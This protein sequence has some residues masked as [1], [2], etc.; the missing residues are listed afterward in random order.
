VDLGGPVA[1][2][3]VLDRL[4]VARE[5]PRHA[6][7]IRRSIASRG[8]YYAAVAHPCRACIDP[9][10]DAATRDASLPNRRI[11]RDFGLSETSVRRHRRHLDRQPARVKPGPTLEP[12]GAPGRAKR[13]NLRHRPQ[14]VTRARER[15][16]EEQKARYLKTVGQVGTLTAGCRAAR[17]SPH[18]VYAWRE[19]DLAFAMA[20]NEAR[21]AFADGIEE[22]AIRRAWHGI[23]RPIYQGGKLVGYETVYSDNLLLQLLKALKPEKYRERLDLSVNTVVKEV[24]GFNPKDVL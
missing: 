11:A 24:A 14:D 9:S 18:T 6:L 10:V 4:A 13:A 3:D 2:G 5:L 7:G 12:A 21:A 16:Q 17:C 19:Q 1:R 15:H 8:R 23:K 22:E 20:E